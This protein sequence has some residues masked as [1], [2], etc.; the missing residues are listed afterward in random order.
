MDGFI[1]ARAGGSDRRVGPLRV[2]ER[3]R[4]AGGVSQGYSSDLW[5]LGR[6]GLRSKTYGLPR[7]QVVCERWLEQSANVSGLEAIASAKMESRALRS[8]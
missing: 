5:T 4:F 7:L 2:E 6:V 1:G 3:T 8:S